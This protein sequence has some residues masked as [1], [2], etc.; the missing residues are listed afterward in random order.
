MHFFRSRLDPQYTEGLISRISLPPR[1]T[2]PGSGNVGIINDF[3]SDE[4]LLQMAE[5]PSFARVKSLLAPTSTSDPLPPVGNRVTEYEWHNPVQAANEETR[6][7]WLHAP[8]FTA[9]N[10]EK[11]EINV[12]L[13]L[14]KLALSIAKASGK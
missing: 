14:N 4:R 3:F 12:A 11:S 9:P 6:G 8:D 1:G 13:W 2:A 5:I 7:R 10:N